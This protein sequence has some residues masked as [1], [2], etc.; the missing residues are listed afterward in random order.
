LTESIVNPILNSPYEQPDR[1]FDIGPSGPR[2]LLTESG[3]C[4]VQIGDE[5]VHLVRSLMDEVFGSEN[6]VSLVAFVTTSGFA[7]ATGLARNGDYV[8]W[9]AKGLDAVKTRQL[10]RRVGARHGY[11]WLRL[12]DGTTRGMTAAEQ[13][14]EQA[15]PVNARVYQP[16]NLI[17]QGA[18]S[19]SQDLQHRGRLYN[20]GLNAHWKP[21][22]PEGMANLARAGRLHVARNSLRYIRFADD[23]SWQSHT[24]NWTD[25]AT[26]NFTDEKIYVVQSGTK[27]I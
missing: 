4:F 22:F 11:R 14:G 16:D 1:Y 7:Q 2:D 20:P 6:F 12:A 18:A 25:T 19:Q 21:S 27:V 10:W 5:N 17:S 24:N 23:F 26:G 3:S 8:L 9:Y 13:S 15:L